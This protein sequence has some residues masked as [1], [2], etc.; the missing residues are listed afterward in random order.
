[1]AG[2]HVPLE[3]TYE[4]DTQGSHLLALPDMTYRRQAI[5]NCEDDGSYLVRCVDEEA[6]RD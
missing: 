6:A 3:M 1:V 5:Q 4:Y 2:T